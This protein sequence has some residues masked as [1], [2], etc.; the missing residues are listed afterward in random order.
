MLPWIDSFLEPIRHEYSLD[1][2]DYRLESP[3]KEEFDYIYQQGKEDDPFDTAGLKQTM[4][5]ALKAKKADVLKASSKYGTC[6]VVSL[7]SSPFKPTWNTWWRAI[8]LLSPQ[9]PVRILFFGHPQMRQ[10]PFNNETP[11]TAQ[12][13]NGG[14][15]MRCDSK[16]IV[17]YRKEEATR[18]LIHELLHAS[19]SDPYTKDTPF[20]EAD[21][22]AWAEMILCAMKA[23]GVSARWRIYMKEQIDW[24]LRQAATLKLKYNVYNSTHYAWRYLVGRLDVWRQLG[25]KI[26]AFPEKFTAVKSLRFTLCEPEDV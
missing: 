26:P 22:E 11:I 21:T 6:L 17:L 5:E 2:P 19:C 14:S 18:V 20:I 24:S 23:K 13:V 25:L 8:R 9:K 10:V 15:A 16:T 7:H 1:P 3:T 4:I 12:Q